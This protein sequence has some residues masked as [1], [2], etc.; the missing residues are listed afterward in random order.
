MTMMRHLAIGLGAALAVGSGWSG[1]AVAADDT[2]VLGAAVSLTGKYSTNGQN[3]K[4]GYDLAVKAINDKGG[5]KVGDKTYK[6]EVIYYDDEFDAGAR[7]AAHRAADRPG[8][9]PVHARAVRLG[10]DQGGGA[11]HREVQGADGRGERRRARAVHPGLQVHLRGALDL[12]LLPARRHQAGRRAGR[13]GGHGSVRGDGRDRGRERPVLARRARRRDR[14][15]REV[16]HAGRDRRQAAARAQRHVGDAH[17]G[18]GAEAG[19]PGGLG[20]REGTAARDPA[21]AGDARRRA[22]AGPDPLRFRPG[23]RTDGRGGG[24]RAVRLAVGRLARL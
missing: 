13:G 10:P 8:R 1:A 3:T 19:R 4:D 12:G 7:G 17:Q 14:G 11:D 23:R 2:I 20:A 21:D 24:V 5:V 22:D 18:E 6:L 9:R 16:R 15:H